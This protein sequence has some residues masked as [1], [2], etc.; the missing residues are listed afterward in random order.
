M[1]LKP[2]TAAAIEGRTI[3]PKRRRA[4]DSIARILQPVSSNAKLGKGRATI[5][6]GAWRGFPLFSLTL[7]ERATCPRSCPQWLSCYGNNMRFATRVQHGA[8]LQR[9]L[10]WELRDLAYRYPNGFAVRLHILGD[11]YSVA[12]ARFWRAQ[13]HEIPQLHLYGYTHRDPRSTIGGILH[14]MN[15]S[16]R[17]WIRFSDYFDSGAVYG[18]TASV[19]QQ[20][21]TKPDGIPCPEQTGKTESCLTCGLCWAARKRILFLAH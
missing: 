4:P 15:I 11:F 9:A 10:R 2:T 14:E 17:C 3:H 7:E 8:A 6:R 16:P 20:W 5:T 18:L 13:L 21:P 19:V 1:I 12:Y